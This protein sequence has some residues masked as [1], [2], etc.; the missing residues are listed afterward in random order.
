MWRK[1]WREWL[2]P[3]V[4]AVGVSLLVRSFVAEARI[5]PT[6]SM[7]PTIQISDRVLVDKFFFR[8]G[9]LQRGDVVVFWP[10][11]GVENEYPFIKRLIGLPGDTI[12]ISGGELY[13]N[14]LPAE[15]PY[16]N[17]Q[18]HDSYGPVTVPAGKLF[19][20]GDNRNGSMD[21]RVWGF[22]DQTEVIGKAD[23]VIWP[24][25]HIGKI[26]TE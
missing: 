20:M 2:V 21:S 25:S 7:E 11:A 13:V 5:I 19:M 15:E 4:I 1:L 18:W 17:G 26:N 23:W 3:L 12:S 22:V 6:G 14:G 10:P 24:P 9:E 16:V 8:R